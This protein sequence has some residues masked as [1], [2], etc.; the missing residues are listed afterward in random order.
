MSTPTG[1][2]TDKEGDQSTKYCGSEDLGGELPCHCF[3]QDNGVGGVYPMY[4]SVKIMF[5]LRRANFRTTGHAVD[6]RVEGR[7][8]KQ[9]GG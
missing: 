6:K 8:P 7:A 2:S 3:Q 9:V 4:T 5:K 1:G